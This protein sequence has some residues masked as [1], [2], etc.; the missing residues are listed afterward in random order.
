ML[1]LT[2]ARCTTDQKYHTRAEA[3][4]F[5]IGDRVASK[6]DNR[7][8]KWPGDV[9]TRYAAE[10]G[11]ATYSVSFHNGDVA[12]VIKERFLTK[13]PPAPRRPISILEPLAG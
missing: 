1:Y 3:F 8:Y 12:A 4:K 6:N 5:Q 13:Q 9:F 10:D 2:L 11:T 7:Y